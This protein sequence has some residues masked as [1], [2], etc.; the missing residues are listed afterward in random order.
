[1]TVTL[2]D[3]VASRLSD[4]DMAMVRSVPP[5]GNWTNIPESIPSKRLEQIRAMAKDRGGVV[6]TTYY[7]RLRSDRP[8]YTIS[9]HFQR[10]GNGCNIHPVEDRTLTIREAARLQSFPDRI[11]FAG[12]QAARRKQVG[13][14]VPVLLARAVGT[15]FPVGNVVDL[16]AGAGGLGLG[17]ALA[18]HKIEVST[19]NDSAALGVHAQIHPGARH[20]LGDIDSPDVQEEVIRAGR[21][22]DLLVGGPPCQGWSYAGWHMHTDPRNR[23]VWTFISMTEKIRPRRFLMENVQGLIWMAN[24]A[25]LGA[26]VSS[27]EALGYRVAHYVLNAASYGVPQR[28]HRLFVVG[29]LDGEPPRAP[30]P[31]FAPDGLFLP[32]P[33]TVGEAIGDLPPL[34]QGLGADLIE[35]QAAPV[36]PYQSWARGLLNFD[37]MY[38]ALTESHRQAL[39]LTG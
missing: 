12:G 23:L 10:P 18:G 38:A 30:E 15:T 1:M 4:L 5:G 16:F 20:I 11:A 24:G 13:N 29:S 39:R 25:A 28:R 35:W 27:F 33:V 3:H 36:T 21:S 26:I 17:L 34:G 14:A 22:C 32:P 31:L 8:S 19:D 2:F 7:G 37:E 6:R 9:T